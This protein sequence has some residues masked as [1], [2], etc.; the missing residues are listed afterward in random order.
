MKNIVKIQTHWLLY[1]LVVQVTIFIHQ[2]RIIVSNIPISLRSIILK[3]RLMPMKLIVAVT[4]KKMLP[5][6]RMCVYTHIYEMSCK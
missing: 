2:L 1:L 6:V 5:Y 3:I 4:L